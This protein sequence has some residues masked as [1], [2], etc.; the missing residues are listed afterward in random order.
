MTLTLNLNLYLSTYTITVSC[1]YAIYTYNIANPLLPRGLDN[2]QY[3]L[4]KSS[5]VKISVRRTD[6]NR[7]GSIMKGANNIWK[8]SK[9]LIVIKE[10]HIYQYADECTLF[11]KYVLFTDMRMEDMKMKRFWF[12]KFKHYK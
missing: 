6:T 3:T 2:I 9:V 1:P 5:L 10:N 7:F 8:L 12:K 4:L 11:N